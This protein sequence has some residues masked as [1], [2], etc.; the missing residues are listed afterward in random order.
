MKLLARKL[1]VLLGNERWEPQEPLGQMD[2][3]WE[4]QLLVCVCHVS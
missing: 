4:A 3:T 2:S 1:E